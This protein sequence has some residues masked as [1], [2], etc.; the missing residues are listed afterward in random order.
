MRALNSF[1]LILLTGIFFLANSGMLFARMSSGSGKPCEGSTLKPLDQEICLR[2]CGTCKG[3]TNV[4]DYIDK[5]GCIEEATC[6]G[7]R[8][9]EDCPPDALETDG[10]LP[11]N[12]FMDALQEAFT[13]GDATVTT[14]TDNVQE[15]TTDGTVTRQAADAPSNI[16]LTEPQG[17]AAA[18]VTTDVVD[19]KTGYTVT[20]PATKVQPI[21]GT[22]IV[23]DAGVAST[24]LITT[25][26]TS[27][28]VL[29]ATTTAGS[30]P[31]CVPDLTRKRMRACLQLNLVIRFLAPVFPSFKDIGIY[32]TLDCHVFPRNQ[33]KVVSDGDGKEEYNGIGVYYAKCTLGHTAEEVA[34]NEETY[35]GHP[36]CKNPLPGGQLIGLFD[37]MWDME[38]PDY[39]DTKS[40]PEKLL[41]HSFGPNYKEELAKSMLYFPEIVIYCLNEN[42]SIL[43]AWDAGCRNYCQ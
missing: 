8:K 17:K 6:D 38:T 35:F 26:T 27:I 19:P 41:E 40:V 4:H 5:Y 14:T 16:T 31:S 24:N 13:T 43:N 2:L 20:A 22:A 15:V 3:C 34:P 18:K 23:E 39:Q 33:W 36:A 37:R 11:N 21:V 32:G 28:G 12:I 7:E 42:D 9:I 29:S 1:L 25:S 30:G 10:E